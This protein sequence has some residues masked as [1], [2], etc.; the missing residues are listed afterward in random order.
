MDRAFFQEVLE[1]RHHPLYGVGLIFGELRMISVEKERGKIK[2][3][4]EGH[5]KEIQM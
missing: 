4:Y 2:V 1:Q 5:M 3:V